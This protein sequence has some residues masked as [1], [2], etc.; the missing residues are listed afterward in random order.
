MHYICLYIIESPTDGVHP[1][2]EADSDDDVT[3]VFINEWL[4]AIVDSIIGYIIVQILGWKGI[5]N[6]GKAQLS[7]DLD[8]LRFV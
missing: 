4:G 1:S 7:V 5:G 6:S 2:G 3:G 8:Y